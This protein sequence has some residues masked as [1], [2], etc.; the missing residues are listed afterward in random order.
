MDISQDDKKI[1]ICAEL[2]GVQQ[3]DIDLNIEDGV[4]TLTGEKKSE[5]KDDSGYSERS[6]G[7]FERR[8]TLPS[9]IDEEQC[10]ADFVQGVLKIT[11]PKSAAKARG[12]R[13]PLGLSAPQKGGKPED[14]LIDQKDKNK[15]QAG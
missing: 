4:L 11:L 2:P 1:E 12:R 10:K 13:I 15:A 8:I 6:Y 9:N 7:R 14:A 3:E 5:R